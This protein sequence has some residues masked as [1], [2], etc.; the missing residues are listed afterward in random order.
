MLSHGEKISTWNL[1]NDQTI[2][3]SYKIYNEFYKGHLFGSTLTV[4]FGYN[5]DF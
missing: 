4:D 2:E 1:D 5:N 3:P